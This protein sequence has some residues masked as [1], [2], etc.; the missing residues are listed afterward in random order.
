MKGFIEEWSEGGNRR[1]DGK[2][3]IAGYGILHSKVILG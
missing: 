2:E 1:S 3:R